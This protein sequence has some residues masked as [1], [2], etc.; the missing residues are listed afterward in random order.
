MLVATLPLIACAT[1]R[2]VPQP[3][4]APPLTDAEQVEIAAIEQVV[5]D[6]CPRAE[7]LTGRKGCA[8]P[9]M[10]L[11]GDRAAYSRHRIRSSSREPTCQTT[12]RPLRI[13]TAG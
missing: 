5:T 13:L 12:G 2:T 10:I 4:L 8:R 3:T 7:V 6:Y 9:R 11:I 1:P